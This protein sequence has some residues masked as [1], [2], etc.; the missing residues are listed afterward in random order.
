MMFTESFHIGARKQQNPEED[1]L[2]VAWVIGVHDMDTHV[3]A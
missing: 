1:D 2:G 3:T